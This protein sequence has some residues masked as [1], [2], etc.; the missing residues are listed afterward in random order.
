MGETF[1]A[2]CRMDG[3]MDGDGISEEIM[4]MNGFMGAVHA[5]G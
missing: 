2:K 4:R 5:A 1:Q 3:W